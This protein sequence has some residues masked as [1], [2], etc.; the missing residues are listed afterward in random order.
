MTDGAILDHISS[1]PH[2]RGTFKQLVKEL[3]AKGASRDG[4]EAALDRLT[5]RGDLLELRSGH[6]SVTA[7]S[8]EFAVG[9]L[10]MHRDGYGFL[11]SERPIEGVAGDIFI[12]PDSAAQ[13]MHGDR[14]VV[15]IAR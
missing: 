11:I 10:N 15:R 4:L 9:R 3:G 14:V 6:F 12:P 8:R 2:A 7:R 13:A 1:L 5:A